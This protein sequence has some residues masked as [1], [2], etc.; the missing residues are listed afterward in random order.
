MPTQHRIKHGE[1]LGSLG[2]RYGFDPETLWDHQDNTEL[3]RTRKDSRVLKP[4]DV[5]LIPDKQS[6]SQSCATEQKHRFRRKGVPETIRIV[7]TDMNGYARSDIPWRA[8][9]EGAEFDGISDSEGAIELKIPP[10]ADSAQLIVGEAETEVYDLQF[11]GT[12]PVDDDKGVQQRLRN[13]GYD[14][15]P[16]DGAIGGKTRA[17]LVAFQQARGLAAT[18]DAD[19]ETRRALV[20]VHQS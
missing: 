10:H 20:D 8:R 19:D 6:R 7:L 17:A 2:A 16:I 14:C 3:R 9:V 1:C 18:G 15:G 5:V 13:L 11:G 12:D 4:G